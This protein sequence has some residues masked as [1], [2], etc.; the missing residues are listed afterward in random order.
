MSESRVSGHAPIADFIKETLR[1]IKAADDKG[2]ILRVMGACAFRIHCK[3]CGYLHATL[4]RELTDID[5]VTYNKYSGELVPLFVELGYE[6][7]ERIISLYGDRR[8]I[9]YDNKNKRIV[10]IF[11]DKLC[12][13]HTIDYK[14]R[15]ELDHPTVTVSDLLLQKIQIVKINEKDIKDSIMLIREHDVG[16]NEKETINAKYI[17]KVFSNDWGFYYTG[18]TNLK[19][20]KEFLNVYGVLT[21]EDK[22]DVSKKIDELLDY[23][24]NE[25]KTFG[26]RLRAKIGTKRRWYEEVEDIVH[27]KR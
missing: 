1:I 10:D 25:P 9:Y 21:E 15:L 14:G 24:E 18:T 11:I 20:I 23:I 8:H 17:A 22:G 6:P 2:I 12:M 26:W 4:T 19:K 5:F 3:K 16:T 27:S 7:D 13:S